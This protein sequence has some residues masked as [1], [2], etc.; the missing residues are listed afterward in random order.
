MS[1]D[2]N[3]DITLDE[4]YYTIIDNIKKD[5]NIIESI[6]AMISNPNLLNLQDKNGNTILIFATIL[7]KFDIINQIIKKLN[8]NKICIKID[9]VNIKGNSFFEYYFK[10][11]DHD[12]N[13]VINLLN[14]LVKICNFDIYFTNTIGL[15][16]FNYIN[17][18]EEENLIYSDLFAKYNIQNIKKN[19]KNFFDTYRNIIIKG[20]F[21]TDITILMFLIIYKE[22]DLVKYLFNN[23]SPINILYKDSKGKD[24]LQLTPYTNMTYKITQLLI[25]EAKTNL[26]KEEYQKFVFRL[27]SESEPNA[28]LLDNTIIN[29]LEF[30]YDNTYT[31]DLDINYRNKL[32]VLLN[33]GFKINV[34]TTSDYIPIQS[35]LKNGIK[36]SLDITSDYIQIQSFLLSLTL[37]N[38][39]KYN[40]DI[41]NVTLFKKY[42]DNSNKIDIVEAINFENIKD[43]NCLTYAI[44][45]DVEEDIINIILEYN[46]V[47]Q[48]K[49]VD[50][51]IIKE[52]LHKKNL[53]QNLLRSE[54]V[55]KEIENQEKIKAD[56]KKEKVLKADTIKEKLEE[57]FEEKM[58]GK[59]EAKEEIKELEEET[60]LKNYEQQIKEIDDITKETIYHN[61]KISDI[62]NEII[63]IQNKLE[64]TINL[65]QLNS[66]EVINKD[67]SGFILDK[68]YFS[69]T[70]C[71]IIMCGVL[72]IVCY[73]SN[74]KEDMKESIGVHGLWPETKFKKY[75]NSKNKTKDFKRLNEIETNINIGLKYTNFGNYIDNNKQKYSCHPIVEEELKKIEWNKHG[76]YANNYDNVD[77]YFIEMCELGKP[78]INLIKKHI[79]ES[80]VDEKTYDFESIKNIIIS[81][82]FNQYLKNIKDD[83]NID[84]NIANKS[85]YSQEF[86]F[87]ICRIKLRINNKDV[88]KWKFCMSD[89]SQVVS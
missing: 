43:D 50:D 52:Y 59:K 39:Y 57:E 37:M 11:L 62:Q 30:Y 8:D 35:S 40:T 60:V 85:F 17:S 26:N 48:E 68:T 70:N 74:T 5:I 78:V 42:I 58:K 10:S 33:N 51:P 82:N 20:P 14:Y 22:I 87:N 21:N 44:L 67:N 76:I 36:V 16:R 18:L 83:S 66:Y 69:S 53:K 63:N 4:K 64:N 72:S 80:I 25:D 34:D 27:D 77:E 45:S 15:E 71:D 2:I 28:N 81:S 29:V 56:R 47:I 24:A 46:P 6:N 75:K 73:Y 86:Y 84:R 31:L 3:F 49:I 19:T 12:E 55:R 54:K 13:D 32:K 1:K 61:E 41:K 9:L 89:I 65:L 38:D 23:Y 7:K 88:Y 79:C